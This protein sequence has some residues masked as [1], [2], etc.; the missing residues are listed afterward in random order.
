MSCCCFALQG[1]RRCSYTGWLYCSD[2]HTGDTATL[3]AAVLHT[4]DF[5]RRP[6]SA[7]A[8]AF[9]EAIQ[10]QP[11]LHLEA[12]PPV[13]QQRCPQLLRAHELRSRA[14]K[15]IQSAHAAGNP[16]VSC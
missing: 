9:L 13:L 8:A 15:A 11:L 6:V 7:S 10:E 12:I 5:S 14:C 16:Q 4:W 2:C 3:P 1:S